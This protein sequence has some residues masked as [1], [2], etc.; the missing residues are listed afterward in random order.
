MDRLNHF[1]MIFRLALFAVLVLFLAGNVLV[2]SLISKLKNG[3]KRVAVNQQGALK[4][5]LA[6]QAK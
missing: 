6:Q 1:Y 5:Q 3:K 2:A 4:N